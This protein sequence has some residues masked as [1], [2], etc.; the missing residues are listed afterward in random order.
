MFAMD[1]KQD[2]KPE[3]M[4]CLLLFDVAMYSNAKSI[5]CDSAEKN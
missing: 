3:N 5:A 2:I 4:M 1:L